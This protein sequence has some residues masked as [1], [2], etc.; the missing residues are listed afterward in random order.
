[1][2]GIFIRICL[3]LID[4]NSQIVEGKMLVRKITDNIGFEQS[5]EIVR[6]AFLTVAKEFNY[7]K[8]N[9]PGNP[10]FIQTHDLEELYKKGIELFG[11]FCDEKQIGFI[12]IEKVNDSLFFMKRLAV[13]PDFRGSGIGKEIMDF[14]FTYV[15]EHGGKTIGIAVINENNVLKN[16][17]LNYGFK[18]IEVKKYEKLLY[19]ICF[20]EKEV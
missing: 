16:W 17:Y 12:A 7:T 19:E 10:A 9:A 11:F 13:Q 4:D 8:E 18:E 6:T 20:M 3:N 1:V 14:V 5:A 15:S 2:S